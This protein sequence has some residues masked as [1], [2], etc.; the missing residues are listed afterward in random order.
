MPW[1]LHIARSAEKELEGILERARARIEIEDAAKGLGA[2]WE[3]RLHQLA[4]T[5]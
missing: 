2:E 5:G 1:T 4:T 3:D